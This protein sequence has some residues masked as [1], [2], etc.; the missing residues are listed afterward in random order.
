MRKNISIAFTIL[1]SF[2]LF[3]AGSAV[4]SQTGGI[5]T[6]TDTSCINGIS[7]FQKL[8][9]GAKDDLAEWLA[10]TADSGYVIAGHTNSVGN[11]GI[12]GLLTRVNKKGN[13]VW[14]RAVGGSGNDV[15]YGIKR[16]SDNGFIAVGQTKSYGNAAGDAWLVKLDA[17]G[18]IQWSKKY[19]DGNVN[20][21]VAF[22]VIQLSD[23][24][25]A[26]N[27]A[28]QFAPG[29]TESFVVRTDNLGNVL[30]SKQYGHSGSDEAYGITEDGSSLVVVGFYRAP[31]IYD[32]YVMKLD[33]STGAVQWIRTYDADNN[34]HMLMAK[35]RVT[36]VGYQ[37]LSFVMDDF[38]G[39][40]LQQCIWNLN[41]D[42]TVQN[43]RKIVVPGIQT[44][45]YGWYP[46]ADGGFVVANGENNNSAD[47]VFSQV[48]A[49]GTLA[50]SKKYVRNGKQWIRAIIPSPEG[51]YAATGN[52]N[53]AGT[54]VDSTDVYLIRIDSLGNA[55]LCSGINTNDVTVVVPVFTTSVISVPS[56]GNVTNNSPVITVGV[57]SFVPVTKILCYDCKQIIPII[58][59]DTTCSNGISFFQKLYGGAKDDLAEWL[60][61]T[62]DSGYVIAGHTNSVGNGGIDGLLTR[63]N[64][65]GNTVWSRAVGGSGN[66]VLY[67]IK[68]TSDNGFIA[69]GQTK[70]Y[71]NAAGDAWLVKLDASGNIQWSKKY[72]DGN[73]NGDVAFEVIQLS[74]GGYAFNGAHQFAP[75]ATESFVVRTDNLGNVLWSKQYGHSGS[76]EAYG[77]TE[78]GSSLVVVGFYRAP[79]IYDG[80]VMKLD[81]STGAVQWIRTYDA[82]NN[83]HMLM[84][85]IRVTSVGYQVL[86]FVMDD[87]NGTNLQQCIW[88]LNTDGTVQNVRKIVVPG[89]QT[90]GYGWYPQA[91][92]GFVVANGENNNSA[93]IVFSQVNANG[94]LAWSK[95]YVRNGKQ[96]IRAIIPSPEGGYAATGNN[97]N[98]GT[99]VDSTDVYL[100]RIDSLGNAGLCSG[101]NTNDVTVVVP[102]FTTSVI[103]VPSPGNVTINSP[104]IT[105]GVISFVPVTNTLCFYCQ[106]KPTGT[107]RPVTGIR[108]EHILKVYPNPVA[109]GVVN[110][111][112]TAEYEDRAVISIVDLNGNLVSILGSKDISPGNNLMRLDLPR[113]LQSYSNYFIRVKYSAFINSVQIFVINQ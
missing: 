22:E 62:A 89:I 41:T 71:G 8:Y 69:V 90:S 28:H 5:P 113:R 61:A 26:F 49:N 27:G 42:G 54:T 44:S 14:S 83:R 32:G 48:N 86:S 75:G 59:P 102:V 20:G 10:A 68:R 64:K 70:S 12:D 103:S 36:S 52:N 66:D 4:Y 3:L 73:V 34:R 105:V 30:W 57:I 77:I 106:P 16:T 31:N 18:N 63:V 95:K 40:N 65:K 67:G 94:T 25:Y 79:N 85:K 19:G 47:I 43:V 29:A 53:N 74:D 98:A 72:G 80:Y 37:V 92:G 108:T 55:G 84:A 1:F 97:N 81:K 101:I 35:I 51:G 15:L 58:P 100:I 9:G 11:G 38:N 39:T 110:L 107:T 87:F 23:G 96:W 111:S 24:G 50:W 2:F 46:Q 76:D 33:K 104:V 13:T 60:A 21:D 6:G 93:D 99:T 17:S 112:I 45:G 91:D 88:N 7:F 56:P 78:D 109:G 82:D